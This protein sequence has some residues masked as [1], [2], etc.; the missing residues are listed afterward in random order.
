MLLFSKKMPVFRVAGEG[1]LVSIVVFWPFMMFAAWNRLVQTILVA[2][3]FLPSQMERKP[4][5]RKT[6]SLFNANGF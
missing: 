4:I 1:S 5:I 3:R 6:S 2:S